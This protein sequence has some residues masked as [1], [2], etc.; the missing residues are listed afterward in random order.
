VE[1]LGQTTDVH[2]PP[3]HPAVLLG[4][5]LGRVGVDL[6]PRRAVGELEEAGE[7]AVVLGRVGEDGVLEVDTVGEDAVVLI[8]P[9]AG[10]SGR[11]LSSLY[12]H[13]RTKIVSTVH[14]QHTPRTITFLMEAMTRGS[15]TRRTIRFSR[16]VRFSQC[17]EI[18][19]VLDVNVHLSSGHEGIKRP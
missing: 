19:G 3:P 16:F 18:I 5:P 1:F 7:H 9:K 13:T 11:Q 17:V 8:H 15:A 2:A 6:G 10:G 14:I 12:M 4:L